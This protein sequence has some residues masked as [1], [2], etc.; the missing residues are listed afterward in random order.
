MKYVVLQHPDKMPLVVLGMMV[1]HRDLAEPWIARGYRPTSAGFV[2]VL[3]SGRF[4]TFG[5][6]ESLQLTPDRFDDRM[7]ASMHDATVQTA[8]STD[9]AAQPSKP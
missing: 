8:P 2:A 9:Y 1:T 3:P 7:L 5:F 4:R 6:S